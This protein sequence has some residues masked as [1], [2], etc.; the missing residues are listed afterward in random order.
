MEAK[1]GFVLFLALLS[2]LLFGCLTFSTLYNA[3]QIAE[4]QRQLQ[5]I[6]DNCHNDPGSNMQAS[7]KEILTKLINEVN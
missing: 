5:R 6:S 1:D 4:L 2:V 7:E 3:N